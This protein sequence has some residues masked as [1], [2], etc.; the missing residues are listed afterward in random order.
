MLAEKVNI[1]AGERQKTAN[2]HKRR[3]MG[4]AK[5]TC[6]QQIFEKN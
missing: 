6:G 4:I 1:R 5:L 2:N 3:E